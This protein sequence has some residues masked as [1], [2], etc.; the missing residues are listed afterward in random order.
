MINTTSEKLKAR[1]FFICQ[2][3]SFY[4]QLKNFVLSSVED[5]KS[6][7]SSGLVSSILLTPCQ[8]HL[9]P[10]DQLGLSNS[11]LGSNV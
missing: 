1:N 5:E 11:H 7:I 2:Y 3:F 9:G 8:A 4:E 6:F 10:D